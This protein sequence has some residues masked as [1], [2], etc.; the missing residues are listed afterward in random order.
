MY[1]NVFCLFVSFGIQ[2]LIVGY[3]KFSGM[4]KASAGVVPALLAP[5][6]L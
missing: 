1:F 5:E 4:Y 3:T 2:L 6:V